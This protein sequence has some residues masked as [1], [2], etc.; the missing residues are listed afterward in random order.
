M[1]RAQLD[2]RS[3]FSE[4]EERGKARKVSRKRA[5]DSKGGVQRGPPS[6]EAARPRGEDVG[7]HVQI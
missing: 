5:A 2:T 3:V 1:T 6:S 4:G 7:S